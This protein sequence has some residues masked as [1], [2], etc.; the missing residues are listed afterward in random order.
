MTGKDIRKAMLAAIDP[1]LLSPPQSSRHEIDA[2]IVQMADWT[3]L[4]AEG[5]VAG[6][7]PLAAHDEVQAAWWSRYEELESMLAGEHLPYRLS[8][9]MLMVNELTSR[10]VGSPLREGDEIVFSEVVTSP[11]FLPAGLSQPVAAGFCELLAE[12]ALLRRDYQTIG[13][14]ATAAAA[15]E[16]DPHNIHVAA[17]VAMLSRG[18]GHLMEPASE[19]AGVSEYLHGCC[20]VV[21]AHRALVRHPHRLIAHPELAVRLAWYFS[22]GDPHELRLRVSRHFTATLKSLAYDNRCN[23]ARAMS[24]WRAMGYVAAGRA[25]DLASLEAHHH[26]EGSGGGG[27]AVRD[28]HGRALYR[29]WLFQGPDAHRLFWWGGE[30]PEFL[31]VTGHDDPPPI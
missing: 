26:H 23:A 14:V 17:E 16:S 4:L 18:A 24:C 2:W 29:G 8:E 1:T 5:P 15:W 28:R 22:G 10:L 27:K 19:D 21:D 25:A 20:T 13:L 31:G 9:L 6:C 7:C 3:A 11:T 30:T 12:I